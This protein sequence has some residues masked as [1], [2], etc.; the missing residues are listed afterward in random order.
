[1]HLSYRLLLIILIVLPLTAYSRLAY[2][3]QAIQGQFSL[4]W[5]RQPIEGLLHNPQTS[6]ELK[7]KLRQIS[8]MRTFAI[9]TLHLP[10]N[11]SYTSYV[12]LKRQYVVWNVFATPEFSLKP[13]QWCFPVAG[14]VAYRGYFSEAGAHRFAEQLQTQGFD[15]QVSGIQAYS[16]L[17]WFRDPVLNTM[18]VRNESRL[19]GNLFHEL[20]HQKLYVKND[21]SF[22]ESFAMTVELEGMQRWLHQNGNQTTYKHYVKARQRQKQFVSIIG[23]TRT[24]LEKIYQSSIGMESKRKQKRAIFAELKASYRD[25]RKKWR[26]YP[27]YDHWFAR[28]LNNAHLV[29]VG[30]YHDYV[31]AFQAILKNEKNNLT[32]FY[33]AATQLANKKPQDRTKALQRLAK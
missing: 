8:R 5:H 4:L 28:K 24:K 2:Y 19:A 9:E 15:V 30:N 22:N 21:T 16:T 1:M 10:D 7:I 26:G 18:L 29:P 31:P 25:L 6:A 17:G 11:K 13:R 14:C 27:D 20:A 23:R 12:D 3:G 33:Q 32:R